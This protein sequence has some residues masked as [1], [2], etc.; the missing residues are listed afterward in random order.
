MKIAIIRSQIIKVVSE[1]IGISLVNSGFTLAL[2]AGGRMLNLYLCCFVT[3]DP[4]VFAVQNDQMGL[5]LHTQ[6]ISSD[7]VPNR[8]DK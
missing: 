5:K 1:T 7:F 3:I 6:D 4:E 2:R 8:S